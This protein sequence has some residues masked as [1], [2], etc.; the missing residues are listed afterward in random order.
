MLCV[1]RKEKKKKIY[2]KE[3]DYWETEISE[4]RKKS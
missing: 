4:P 2:K 1:V 3:K